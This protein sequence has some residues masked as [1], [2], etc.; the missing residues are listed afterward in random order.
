MDVRLV[1]LALFAEYA[2]LALTAALGYAYHHVVPQQL[3]DALRGYMNQTATGPLQIFGHNA[4]IMA[5][6]SIPFVG[7]IAL[8]VSISATGF[9][10]GAIVGYSPLGQMG[11][12]ALALAYLLTAVMPHGVLELFSYAF[13]AAGSVDATARI[14][15]RRGG[16]LRS[17]SI[18]FAAALALLLAAAYVEWLEIKALSSFLPRF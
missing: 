7:P 5:A 11:P 9:I 4:V 14:L 2:L 13:A 6:D 18:H 15:R 16:A 8:A 12:F 1:L 3:I 10:L 17:W